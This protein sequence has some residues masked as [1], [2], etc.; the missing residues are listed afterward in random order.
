MLK[1]RVTL[2][3]IEYSQNKGLLSRSYFE[4][5]EKR[6][7]DSVCVSLIGR[8][9]GVQVSPNSKHVAY[10]SF[11][12]NKVLVFRVEN[13]EMFSVK[14]TDCFLVGSGLNSPHDLDWIDDEF[15]V[16][17]NREGPAVVLNVFNGFVLKIDEMSNSNSVTSVKKG[18]T[19]RLFFCR[20]DHT[21][22]Y[23]DMDKDWNVISLGNCIPKGVFNVPDG[24]AASPSGERLCLTS[25][26][27][28]RIVIY[29]TESGDFFDLGKTKRPHGVDFIT[30]DL[31]LSTGGGDPFV[32]CWSIK[33]KSIK[34][35]FKALSDEQ[36]SLK[37]SESEGGVKGVCF[38]E[39]LRMIFLTCPNAPFLVFDASFFT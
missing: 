21:L 10:C 33:S 8:S 6:V 17:S 34:F 7:I 29:D 18:D 16:V 32:T 31:V 14:I 39:E 28:D 11:D 30:E 9:E 12:L 36:Y 3:K 24:V 2:R 23:C 35:R 25:A 4:H 37:H 13:S 19:T 5:R 15:I 20:T 1:Q 38:C 27:D 22:D 26:L